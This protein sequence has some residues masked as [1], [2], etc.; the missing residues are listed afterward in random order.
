MLVAFVG[1][2]NFMIEIL[3]VKKDGLKDVLAGQGADCKISRKPNK[4]GDSFMV[5]HL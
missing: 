5:L 2:L 3:K 4:R 1:H